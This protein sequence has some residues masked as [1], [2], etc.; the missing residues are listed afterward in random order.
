VAYI[1]FSF[2]SFFGSNLM[3]VTIL[4]QAAFPPWTKT[5]QLTIFLMMN[6]KHWWLILLDEIC[7]LRLVHPT[8]THG[9][10]HYP[11]ILNI[12]ST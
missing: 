2:I 6:M 7:A 11:L 8:R 4:F 10:K 12:G 5:S 9:Q 1:A 3:C